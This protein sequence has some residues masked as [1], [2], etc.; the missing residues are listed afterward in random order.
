MI[1]PNRVVLTTEPHKSVVD[2]LFS[3]VAKKGPK[4][5]SKVSVA[6]MPPK[7]PNSSA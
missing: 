6:R 2:A 3:R 7:M 5:A 1:A 4:G